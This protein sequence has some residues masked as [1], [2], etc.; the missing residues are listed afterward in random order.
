M[1]VSMW[2]KSST[3]V[4]GDGTLTNS[5]RTYQACISS[6][7]AAATRPFGSRVGQKRG[8]AT[9][10]QAHMVM[11]LLVLRQQLDRLAMVSTH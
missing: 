2:L 4:A 8:R 1:A 10:R 3:R 7:L 6:I 11:M 5:L 9:H